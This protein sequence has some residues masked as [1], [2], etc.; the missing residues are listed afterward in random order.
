MCVCAAAAICTYIHPEIRS[1]PPFRVYVYYIYH[2]THTATEIYTHTRVYIYYIY[3]LRL[4]R[5]LLARYLYAGI[6]DQ[7]I[8]ER[9]VPAFFRLNY[10]YYYLYVA[11]GALIKKGGG[12]IHCSPAR[13]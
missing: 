1:I 3:S 13:K 5:N 10:Y 2:T 9:D 4:S 6:Y 8:I 7:I 11:S 12:G